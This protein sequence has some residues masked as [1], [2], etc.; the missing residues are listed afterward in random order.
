MVTTASRLARSLPRAPPLVRHFHLTDPNRRSR[1]ARW[2]QPI[3]GGPPV[4]GVDDRVLER[5]RK[6]LARAEHPAT[7]PAEAEA[8]SEKAAALMSRYVIDQAMLDSSRSDDVAPVLRQLTVA[9][10]YTLAKAALLTA[11]ARSFR[12]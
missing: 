2:C 6:L 10:P 12:V 3:R 11:V 9:S 1:R 5:V 8:C 7:P 4:P